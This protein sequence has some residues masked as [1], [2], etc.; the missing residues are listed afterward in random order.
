VEEAVDA[1][2]PDLAQF[3]ELLRQRG[4]A[5]TRHRDGGFELD[6][7]EH[8]D[9][10]VTRRLL[11]DARLF[12]EYVDTTTADWALPPGSGDRRDEVLSL[13]AINVEA[14]F[15]SAGAEGR[16]YVTE[17]GLRR[18]GCGGVEWYRTEASPDVEPQV[19]NPD[20][21]W[22]ADRPRTAPADDAEG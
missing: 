2:A 13:M 19:P 8:S 7:P 1:R 16:N 18:A 10:T 6:L 17:L 15:M 22:V 14:L 3:L 11:I 4:L 21:R 12:E 9:E 5:V 20:L